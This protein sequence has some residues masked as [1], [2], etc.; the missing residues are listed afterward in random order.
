MTFCATGYGR[1]SFDV[2][3]TYVCAQ[4][5]KDDLFDHFNCSSLRCRHPFTQVSLRSTGSCSGADNIRRPQLISST[6]RTQI[7]QAAKEA[8]DRAGGGFRLW[9]AAV[10]WTEDATGRCS[11]EARVYAVRA[12]AHTWSKCSLFVALAAVMA[13]WRGVAGGLRALGETL[14]N[15]ADNGSSW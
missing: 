4:R 9:P 6:C 8:V 12:C 10:P 13:Q 14:L 1:V 11:N 15:A 5:C 3:S 2:R 7:D